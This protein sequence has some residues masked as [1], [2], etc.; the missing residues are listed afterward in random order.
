[1][2]WLYIVV[3]FLL[4]INLLL[5][6]EKDWIDNSWDNSAIDEME[7]ENDVF[8][9]MEIKNRSKKEYND[10]VYKYIENRDYNVESNNIEIATVEVDDSLKSSDIV[11]NVLTEDLRVYGDKYKGSSIDIKKNPYKYFVNHDEAS[12]ELFSVKN[13]G[14]DNEDKPKTVVKQ[15]DPLYQKVPDE[16]VAEL[17][18]I[19]LRGKD[20]VKE[21]NVYIKN[22]TIRVGS[23][24]E[25]EE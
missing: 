15:I 23:N 12:F 1:V 6:D 20:R 10:K 4:S 7:H 17:E 19:D 25:D 16:D 18:V 5:A 14:E 9:K 11:V 21:V 13:N 2:K 8:K 24:Y 3:L 22:T